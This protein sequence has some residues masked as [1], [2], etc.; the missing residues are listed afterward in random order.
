MSM[1]GIAFRATRQMRRRIA[2]G[3]AAAL[4]TVAAA[5]FA[6]AAVFLWLLS[7]MPTVA[8]CA[9]MAV[10]LGALAMVCASLGAE[11]PPEPAPQPSPPQD[12]LATLATAFVAAMRVGRG[13]G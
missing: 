8:A 6:G 12:P 2:L 7:A 9:V 3:A 1:T 4:L 10:G 11:D 5:G 13:E